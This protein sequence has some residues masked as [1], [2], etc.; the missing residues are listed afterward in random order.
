MTLCSSDAPETTFTFV[1]FV[2]RP[3]FVKGEVRNHFLS[4]FGALYLYKGGCCVEAG[5]SR[6]RGV[7]SSN[8]ERKGG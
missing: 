6:R 3:G 2:R 8:A 4:E 1:R 5:T 7:S